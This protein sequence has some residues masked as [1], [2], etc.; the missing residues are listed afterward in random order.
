MSRAFAAEGAQYGIRAVT[1]SPGPIQLPETPTTDAYGMESADATAL[2]RRGTVDEIAHAAL[3]L[4]SDEASFMT[5][6][7]LLIDGGKG[8]VAQQAVP[9][10][11]E[12]PRYLTPAATA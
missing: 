9:P 11:G 3:Y 4:A 10:P 6:C 8:G 7:D 2:K 1:I 5:A 12:G